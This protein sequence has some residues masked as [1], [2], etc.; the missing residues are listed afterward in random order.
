MPGREFAR[1]AERMIRFLHDRGFRTLELTLASRAAGKSQIGDSHSLFLSQWFRRNEG[2][3]LVLHN[4]RCYHDFD[5]YTL[6][7]LAFLKKPV[8]SAYLIMHFR[9]HRPEKPPTQVCRK[10]RRK[11]TQSNLA[12]LGLPH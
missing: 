12:Q 11:R 7:S 4:G 3:W 1:A 5:I 6:A 9:W 2:T 8:L 10:P